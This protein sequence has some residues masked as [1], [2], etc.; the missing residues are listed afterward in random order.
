MRRLTARKPG[1]TVRLRIE[2][3]IGDF[4]FGMHRSV[5]AGSGILFRGIREYAPGDPLSSIDWLAS[6]RLSDD[7]ETLVVR[8]YHPDREIQVLVALDIGASMAYPKRKREYGELL[9]WLFALSAFR[10]HDRFQLVFFDASSVICSGWGGSEEWL[11][12]AFFEPSCIGLAPYLNG[13]GLKDTLLAVISDF[14]GMTPEYFRSFSALDTWNRNVHI[15][16]L[17]LDEWEGFTPKRFRA[18]FL[19]VSGHFRDLHLS[20]GKS[21]E[22]EALEYRARLHELKRI[23]RPLGALPIRVPLV[24]DDPLGIVRKVLQRRFE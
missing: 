6:A 13:L 8:E 9:T 3:V 17:P 15:L 19:D 24:S 20:P 22:K 11:S 18:S 5:M 21:A 2:K 14:N 7:D 12:E 23:S 1:G 16:F 4:R 10:S